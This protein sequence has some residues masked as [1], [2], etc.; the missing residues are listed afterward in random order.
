[1][2]IFSAAEA[3]GRNWS[4][5]VEISRTLK[6]VLRSISSPSSATNKLPTCRILH[7]RLFKSFPKVSVTLLSPPITISLAVRATTIVVAWSGA[8]P[9]RQRTTN[10]RVGSRFR[11]LAPAGLALAESVDG[12]FRIIGLPVKP[13]VLE[14]CNLRQ[15]FAGKRPV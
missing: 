3:V 5:A 14:H 11:I 7:A 2:L 9:Q 6:P 4:A 8:A 15:L 1:M 13:I 12:C 10:A